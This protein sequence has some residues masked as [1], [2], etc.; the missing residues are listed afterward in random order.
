MYYR[1]MTY[2]QELTDNL[3]NNIQAGVNSLIDPKLGVGQLHAVQTA[4]AQ[5]GLKGIIV[6]SWTVTDHTIPVMVDG[7]IQ[8][9]ISEELLEADVVVLDDVIRTLGGPELIASLLIG[10]V[11]GQKLRKIPVLVVRDSETLHGFT[12]IN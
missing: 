9:A 2:L 10:S 8:Y 5:L 11:K 7:T 1:T 6:T 12:P 3:S 4:V